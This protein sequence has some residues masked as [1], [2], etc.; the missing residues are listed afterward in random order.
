MLVL[1]CASVAVV[2]TEPCSGITGGGQTEQH[3]S[4]GGVAGP[5]VELLTGRTSMADAIGGL[6]PVSISV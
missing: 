1:P 5:F 6:V 3:L 2:G 4:G